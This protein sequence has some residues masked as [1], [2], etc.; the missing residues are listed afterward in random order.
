MGKDLGEPASAAAPLE[1]EPNGA[2]G[3]APLERHSAEMIPIHTRAYLERFVRRHAA[4]LAQRSTSLCRSMGVSDYA[5]DAV[6]QTLIRLMARGRPI[7]DTGPASALR[8]AMR[9]LRCVCVDECQRRGRQRVVG[10]PAPDEDGSSGDDLLDR[11]ADTLTPDLAAVVDARKSARASVLCFE[12]LPVYA[13]PTHRQAA[14]NLNAFWFASVEGM[15]DDEIAQAL[16]IQ[17]ANRTMRARGRRHLLGWLSALCSVGSLPS[18]DNPTY[19]SAWQLG[20]AAG[21]AFL[22]DHPQ[23]WP[24]GDDDTYET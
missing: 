8:Y 13:D 21:Q 24:L 12:Y 2:V 14:R 18:L 1:E 19:Q 6:Q 10:R 5:E 23:W 11:L 20:F 15:G 9:V 16:G 22:R 7:A 3:D 4:R 17:K